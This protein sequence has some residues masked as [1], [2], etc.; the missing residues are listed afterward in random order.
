M[1]QG[2]NFLT[3]VNRKKAFEKTM[4]LKMNKENVFENVTSLLLDSMGNI[5]DFTN[6]ACFFK[7]EMKRT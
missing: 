7:V 3:K 1:K 5:V 2:E 6:F 4:S